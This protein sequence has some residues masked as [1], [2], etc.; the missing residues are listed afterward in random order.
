[1]NLVSAT[2]NDVRDEL[3]AA[4][5][6]KDFVTD[7]SGVK[8]IEIPGVSFM[9]NEETIFGD[10]K[11]DYVAR[12]LEW[13][14]SMSLNVNDIPPPVPQIWKQVADPDGFINSNYGWMMHHPDNG[15]QF[16][17][18][19][20]ELKANPASRRA[21]AIY[22][23][24]TMW[25]EYNKNGRSD[26]CCTNAVQYLVRKGKVHAVV[27]MRSND[28]VFGYKND[29]AWQQTMLRSVSLCIGVPDGDI[30]WQVGSLHVY[31]RHFYL[32][33]HWWQTGE[34]Y[35]SRADYDEHNPDSGY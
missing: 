17:R 34:P 29:Y 25:D 10:V 2:I 30:V 24:P 19:V 31:E 20:A 11:R 35:I 16:G 1:M 7:K 4:L 3:G 18:V 28:A 26:F 15:N 5:Y 12:E 13:Y 21:V 6:E 14:E 23:R 9:A 32:V 27:Q 8:I 22:T 33:D